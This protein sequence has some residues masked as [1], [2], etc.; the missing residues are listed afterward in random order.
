LW[1]SGI[2]VFCKLITVLGPVL[3]CL[4]CYR[5]CRRL[6][7]HAIQFTHFKQLLGFSAWTLFG[8][9]SGPARAQVP[10]LLL[11]RFIGPLA[12]AAYGVA[13]QVNGF[14]ANIS[15]GLLRAT[16]PAIVK[17]EAGG[18][19]RGMIRL[20]NLSNKYAFLILWLGAGPVIAHANLWLKLWLGQVPPHTAIFATLLLIALLIDQLTS[21]FMAAV[22]AH[23]RI[24]LY[25]MAVSSTTFMTVP[26]G[27][28]FLRIHLPAASVIWAVIIAAS[29]AG[30]ARLTFVRMVLRVNIT[31]WMVQVLFPN[32]IVI[33]VTAT[34]MRAVALS[35]SP[36]ALQLLALLL[37][38]LAL[39]AGLTW[40]LSRSEERSQFRRIALS[41]WS[42]RIK[43]ERALGS[44]KY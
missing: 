30:S 44:V 5:E 34:A 36:S 22:Q 42:R 16:S 33:A 13:M 40:L 17:Y 8:A 29:L 15:S 19:R 23:G 9:L 32:L 35:M 27:Y 12:N 26:L 1:Y 43:Q 4:I 2:Y 3:F 25:Q 18:D 39:T 28:A 37:T 31:E 11:N 41:L 6:R 20:S 38:N 14:T 7:F 24:A 21:G 10:A